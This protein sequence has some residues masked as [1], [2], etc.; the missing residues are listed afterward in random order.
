MDDITLWDAISKVVESGDEEQTIDL[1]ES[2]YM[3]DQND[4]KSEFVKDLA[5]IANSLESRQAGYLVIGV[6]DKKNCTRPSEA[7][8][9]LV[10]IQIGNLNDFEQRHNNILES[11]L[12]S[13]LSA[14]Y[15]PYYHSESQKTILIIV[16]ESW[17]EHDPRPYIVRQ[18]IGKIKRGQIF[19]RDASDI[20]VVADKSM[21]SSFVAKSER[22][23]NQQ[24]IKAMRLD[25]KKKIKKHEQKIKEY[26]NQISN[27]QKIS[28]KDTKDH[29]DVI[30]YLQ[31]ESSER[32]K[33][34]ES[35]HAAEVKRLSDEI[36]NNKK[37]SETERSWLDEN[38]KRL[39]TENDEIAKKERELQRFIPALVNELYRTLPEESR[40]KKI[41]EGIRPADLRSFLSF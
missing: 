4:Q 16:I 11:Y 40:D 24:K 18:D 34:L 36:E 21:L 38:I 3:L 22:T 25:N 30:E 9:Y 31:K 39:E 35:D 20:R 8:Q 17:D 12:S 26:L 33:K 41:R 7:T 37:Q 27:L 19:Y 14:K 29:E 23:E 15:Y 2:L 1:K 28:D 5:A 6:K 10:D 13:K 32:L